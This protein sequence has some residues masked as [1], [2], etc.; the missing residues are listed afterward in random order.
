MHCCIA[1]PTTDNNTS[2]GMIW[3]TLNMDRSAANRQGNVMQIHVV[4]RV[5]ILCERI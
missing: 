3:V 5:V 1:T 4:W 2:T